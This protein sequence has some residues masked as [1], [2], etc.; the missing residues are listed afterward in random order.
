[1]ISFANRTTGLGHFKKQRKSSVFTSFSYQR[2]KCFADGVLRN[3]CRVPENDKNL[4]VF[5]VNPMVLSFIFNDWHQSPLSRRVGTGFGT[6]DANRN[7]FCRMRPITKSI[8]GTASTRLRLTPGNFRR[9]RLWY[10]QH[11][12]LTPEVTQFVGERPTDIGAVGTCE[13]NVRIPTCRETDSRDST[14]RKEYGN[15]FSFCFNGSR[16]YLACVGRLR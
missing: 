16:R 11:A 5:R 13:H 12:R 9:K 15:E 14:S 8:G 1:M 2:K 10:R 6:A 3:Q 7:L 4:A